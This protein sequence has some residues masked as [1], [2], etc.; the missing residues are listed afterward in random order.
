MGRQTSRFATGHERDEWP[1]RADALG[2]LCSCA[3]LAVVAWCGAIFA[4]GRVADD[5]ELLDKNP[6]L[7]GSTGW[8]DIFLRDFWSHTRASGLYRP[9]V[10]VSLRLDGLLFGSSTAALHA[11]N[12]VWHTLVVLLAGALLA[13]LAPYPKLAAWPWLGLLWFAAHPALS[14]A[15]AWISGRSSMLSAAGALTAMLAIAFAY[16]PWREAGPL[17][18]S[19][20]L[21]IVLIGCLASLSAKEDALILVF[22]S[23]LVAWRCSARLGRQALAAAALAVA[24]W[25]VLRSLALESWALRMSFAPL[26]RSSL[27]ERLAVGGRAMLE[28][29]RLAAVPLGYP[30]VYDRH[31]GF[32]PAWAAHG[33]QGRWLVALGWILWIVW[34]LAS[35]RAVRRAPRAVVAWSS[36]LSATSL[37]AYQ[38]WVPLGAVF[39]PRFLYLPFLLAVPLVGAILERA[40]QALPAGLPRTLA[41]SLLAALFAVGAWHRSAVYADRA[42]YQGEVL[43]H[44]PR[45]YAAWNNLGVHHW[46]RA[47]SGQARRCFERAIEIEP[48]YSKP[49]VNLGGLCFEAGDRARA[50]EL[51]FAATRLEARNTT[52]WINLGRVELAL[53]HAPAAR[54]AFERSLE[55]AP[56]SAQAW[57]GLARAHDAAGEID[58]ACAAYRRALELDRQLDLARRRLRELDCLATA[59]E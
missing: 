37:I 47:E 38:H 26:E 32:Q 14:D 22:A 29:L 13:L 10:H 46:E 56:S 35:A 44:V 30:P 40:L 39:A 7:L 27:G 54:A 57:L 8:G 21:A 28:G 58:A 42:S 43:R 12:V 19:A 15:V 11:S 50:R 31:P 18:R 36:L 25:Y 53:E 45:D 3:V 4:G 33:A 17:R 6:A 20:V 59:R 55:L 51:F 16:V 1:A 41:T 24:I 23:V 48:R 52:A 49:Y 34:W 2:R 9:L 5:F